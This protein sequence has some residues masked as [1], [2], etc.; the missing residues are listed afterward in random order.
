[1]GFR[2]I[3][4]AVLRFLRPVVRSRYSYDGGWFFH[5]FNI[6]PW[7]VAVAI[8]QTAW[9][10][11][12]NLLLI[13]Y[14]KLLIFISMLSTHVAKD[15]SSGADLHFETGF[16]LVAKRPLGLLSVSPSCWGGDGGHEEV[17]TPMAKCWWWWREIWQWRW[18][19]WSWKGEL[20]WRGR[21]W[22]WAEIA[23]HGQI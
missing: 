22:R 7:H 18:W 1:M 8:C 11:P 21:W 14:K 3:S 5:N 20:Q 4:K 9:N 10:F 2:A 13:L 15:K 6:R 19:W 17:E 16:E 23:T 12:T